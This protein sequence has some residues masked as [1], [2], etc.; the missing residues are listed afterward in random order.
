MRLSNALFVVALACSWVGTDQ[1][2]ALAPTLAHVQDQ[3]QPGTPFGVQG[4][5]TAQTDDCT[6]ACQAAYFVPTKSSSAFQLVYDLP[7]HPLRDDFPANTLLAYQRQFDPHFRMEDVEQCGV[8]A[9]DRVDRAR[10]D[11]PYTLLAS[12]NRIWVYAHP[13]SLGV[14]AGWIDDAATLQHIAVDRTP[15]IG[16]I[17]VIEANTLG[18]GPQGH[19]IYVSQID[20]IHHTFRGEEYNWF[21]ANAYDNRVVPWAGVK[22]VHFQLR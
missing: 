4:S 20:S 14:P 15:H 10:H 19:A 12:L 21:N 9:L 22:F 13:G 17:A 16:A 3:T 2:E 8:F 18:A 5:A 1:G 7:A 6:A 11:G